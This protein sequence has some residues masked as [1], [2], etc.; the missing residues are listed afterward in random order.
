MKDVYTASLGRNDYTVEID[1]WYD[2]SD[3]F[4]TAELTEDV[5]LPWLPNMA[6]NSKNY[7]WF[8]HNIWYNVTN[9]LN[10]QELTM[11]TVVERKK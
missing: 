11:K 6:P 9:P 1:F 3:Q 2:E 5:S 7:S 8:R 4:P 10:L